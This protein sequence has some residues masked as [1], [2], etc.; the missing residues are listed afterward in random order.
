MSPTRKI[1]LATMVPFA[2]WSTA[3][4]ALAGE[5]VVDISAYVIKAGSGVE[6]TDIYPVI[7][8]QGVARGEYG[9]VLN[10]SLKIWYRVKG[11]T[12]KRDKK[13]FET[14]IRLLSNGKFHSVRINR[15]RS[16]RVE[17]TTFNYIP[18][19]V[20]PSKLCN[21]R[22][23]TLRGKARK[24]F[25]NKGELIKL[26]NAYTLRATS[27]WEVKAGWANTDTRTWDDSYYVP[28]FVRCRPTGH[29]AGKATTTTTTPLDPSRFPQGQSRK[30]TISNL[31]LKI[32]PMSVKRVGKW[33]C[34]TQL[35][36]SG[37]IDVIRPF[38]GDS[39]FVGPRWLSRKTKIKFQS[40]KGRYVTATYDMN[41]ARSGLHSLSAASS[42]KPSRQT[43][44]FK[45][46]VAGADGKLIKSA[47]KR[48]KVVCKKPRRGHGDQA[49]GEITG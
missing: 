20:S 16:V 45:F 30:P 33:I 48:I 38:S 14:Y 17:K 9:K 47:P 7:E 27:R 5:P 6:P 32:T 26:D 2:A 10:N 44:D 23:S 11:S 29:F 42:D 31:T 36:L 4:P 41:W 35:R 12:P 19:R 22:A 13:Y 43:L 49:A 34:P 46:N 1:L 21:D 39:I 15:P 40:A 24:K 3:G 28:A 25:L 8:V 18:P 37:R